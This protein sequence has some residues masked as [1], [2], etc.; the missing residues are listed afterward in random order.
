VNDHGRK[1]ETID[2]LQAVGREKVGGKIDLV[3]KAA[4]SKTE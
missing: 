1:K 3:G 2:P 4:A